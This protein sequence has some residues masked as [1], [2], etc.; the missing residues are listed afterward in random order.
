MGSHEP[1]NSVTALKN[2]G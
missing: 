2:N 1:T